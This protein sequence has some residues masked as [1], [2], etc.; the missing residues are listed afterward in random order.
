MALDNNEPGF[1]DGLFSVQLILDTGSVD[2]DSLVATVR[3]ENGGII[4]S[5]TLIPRA[6]PEP[7]T[8]ALL[9]L[10]LAGIGFSRR[11]H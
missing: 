7:A 10:G 4:A 11:K 8:L 9:S 5:Q 2:I 1:L 3:N 6:V